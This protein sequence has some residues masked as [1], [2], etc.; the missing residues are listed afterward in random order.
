MF[1]PTAKVVTRSEGDCYSFQGEGMS[2][3]TS[4]LG[5]Y[6][7]SSSWGLGHP[8]GWRGRYPGRMGFLVGWGIQGVW[9]AWSR[10]QGVGYPGSKAFRGVGYL[11]G[12]QGIGYPTNLMKTFEE[13]SSNPRF[14]LSTRQPAGRVIE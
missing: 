4:L 14:I 1:L 5:L 13:N 3:A 7:H 6:C 8:T 10:D 9:Y 2:G 12:I 11:W